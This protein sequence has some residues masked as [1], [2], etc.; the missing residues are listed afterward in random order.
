MSSSG[1]QKKG[2]K[3]D[4]SVLGIYHQEVPWGWVGEWLGMEE[5]GWVGVQ[6][7]EGMEGNHSVSIGER[8]K[9]S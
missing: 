5:K 2:L 4:H 6:D 9:C 3:L 8:A 7:C 1:S